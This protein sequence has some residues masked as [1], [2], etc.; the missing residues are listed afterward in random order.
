MIY[1]KKVSYLTFTDQSQDSDSVSSYA[2]LVL[3]FI[4]N[5]LSDEEKL[6]A[7]LYSLENKFTTSDVQL[8]NGTNYTSYISSDEVNKRYQDLF[9][10]DAPS[11]IEDVSAGCPVYHYDQ[12]T[13]AYYTFDGCGGVS[14]YSDLIYKSDYKVED[15]K[16]YVEIKVGS[17]FL[18]LENEQAGAVIYNNLYES[19]DKKAVK[20]LA[21]FET[22]E[23]LANYIITEEESDLFT[24]YT[25]VFTQDSDGNFVFDS[26]E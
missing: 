22:A 7:V 8:D 10:V 4:N 14:G 18:D 15:N 11:D 13:N 12:E 23:D 6:Y 25:V 9:G 5:E 26:V 21:D 1:R 19:E 24:S 16:A 17:V 20:T 3:K 2:T